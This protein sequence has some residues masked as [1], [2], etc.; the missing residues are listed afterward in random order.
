MRALPL[1]TT[2]LEKRTIFFWHKDLNFIATAWPSH[3]TVSLRHCIFVG[4]EAVLQDKV[5]CRYMVSKMYS[6]ILSVF[7]PLRHRENLWTIK[8]EP[9]TLITWKLTW[10][11]RPPQNFG[12]SSF[13]A[14]YWKLTWEFR[15][16]QNFGH[17]SFVALC[18]I[19]GICYN[20]YWASARKFS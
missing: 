5:C 4:G 17:S 12:H 14:L 15:P 8:R 1:E 20:V 6:G 7:G 2:C 19:S 3:Q 10:E 11:F 13:V 16:P 18:C 9:L